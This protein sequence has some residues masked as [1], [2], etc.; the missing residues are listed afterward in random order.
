MRTR[1]YHPTSQ[2]M[3]VFLLLL[4]ANKKLV[5]VSVCTAG[6]MSAAL[7]RKAVAQELNNGEDGSNIADEEKA[8]A[9]QRKLTDDD[10]V[11]TQQQQ[12]K[13]KKKKKK[14][15]LGLPAP[16]FDDADGGGGVDPVV[17]VDEKGRVRTF[18]HQTGNFAVHVW[19]QFSTEAPDALRTSMKEA[20]AAASQDAEGGRV[21]PLEAGELHVS[22]SRTFP[23]RFHE[24]APF[25][26]ALRAQVASAAV[27]PFNA[28]L[29][30]MRWLVNDERTR[31]FVAVAVQ[32]QEAQHAY[33]RLV[34]AVNTCCAS[35]RAPSYYAD[36][37]LHLSCG[38]MAGDALEKRAYGDAGA[39]GVL[40]EPLE[41]RFSAV[42]IKLAQRTSIIPL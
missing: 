20:L 38:W 17:Q 1:S 14:S 10:I 7:K 36:P 16:V 31:S 9:K 30:S 39:L 11:N 13:K 26:T 5:S 18:A 32:E 4:Q 41:L 19:L 27:A 40:R 6:W 28:A 35:F 37:L 24:L 22:L 3:W 42:H 21:E 34:A 2:C 25:E 12:P 29:G 15:G 33:L 23:L 8:R